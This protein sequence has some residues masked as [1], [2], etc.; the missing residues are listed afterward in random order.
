[1]R[2]EILAVVFLGVATLVSAQTVEVSGLPPAP[3]LLGETEDETSVA[4]RLESYE[5]TVRIHGFLAETTILMSF[6]NSDS[7][8]L[9]GELVFALPEGATVSGYGLDVEGVMV[10][11]VAVE[12]HKARIVFER[13]SRKRVDPG[14]VEWL[15]GSLFRTRVYPILGESWRLIKVQ[16]VSDLQIDDGR[17]SYTLPLAH[18]PSLERLKVEV[19]VH[20][21][22]MP[23]IVQS[24]PFTELSFVGEGKRHTLTV[25]SEEIRPAQDLELTSF[26]PSATTV[27]VDEYGNGEHAFAIANVL[28]TDLVTRRRRSAPN[29]IAILW[30]AS[31][32]RV[33][34]DH[35]AVIDL[36]ESVLSQWRPREV[37]LTVFRD[38]PEEPKKFR[39][40][41]G[42]NQELLDSLASTPYDGATRWDTLGELDEFDADAIIL[43]TDGRATLGAS[44]LPASETPVFAVSASQMA[45]HRI[46]QYLA[47][48]SG[49]FYANLAQLPASRVA[50][51]FA[52]IPFTLLDVQVVEGGIDNISAPTG[53]PILGTTLVSG[54]LKGQH[55]KLR[56]EYGLDGRVMRAVDVTINGALGTGM[57][58][59]FWAQSQVDDLSVFLDENRAAILALG[60]QHGLVTPHTSLMVLE[61]LD[62]Y[63]EYR[64]E[65]PATLPEMR[66]EYLAKITSL[67]EEESETEA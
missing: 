1:M 22:E 25:Q 37:L 18:L 33:D 10:D 46:L 12:K 26:F 7:R 65:P 51:G 19:E 67:E 55:G 14:L 50:E 49:G 40:R 17:A 13:E 53:R 11:G 6:F 56:L 24:H 47:E 32:S 8:E 44:L 38:H 64:I 34:S 20:G 58:K 28:E 16:Y 35:A 66:D 21:A 45:E 57:V 5:A 48:S 27:M 42:R 9:A 39:L 29:R 52:Y 30:D 31:F 62:Q 36:L 2:T 4:V 3:V 61:T 63:L 54:L 43:V 60:R 59:R 23:P 41:R 15:G